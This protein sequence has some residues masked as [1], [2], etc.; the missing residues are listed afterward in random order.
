MSGSTTPNLGRFGALMLAPQTALGTALTDAQFTAAAFGLRVTQFAG[1]LVTVTRTRDDFAD[2]SIFQQQERT[3]GRRFDGRTVAFDADMG[4]VSK[5][6][7]AMFGAPAA[8]KITPANGNFAE[9]APGTP[10]QFR[11]KYPGSN[12]KGKD[13]QLAGLTLTVPNRANVTGQL[14]LN[15]VS[16][17]DDPA[18]LTAVIPVTNQLQF[19]HWYV[20]YGGTLYKPE[21]GSLTIT[22]PM[23]AVDGANGTVPADADYIFGWEVSGPLTFQ[24]QITLAGVPAVFRDAYRNGTLAPF[25]FGFQVGA[26]T[27]EALFKNAEVNMLDVPTG[28]GRVATPI[29]LT[30]ATVDGTAPVEFTVPAP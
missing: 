25:V 24:A 21:A 5:I 10:M 27:F 22:V 12:V 9:N 2:G 1:P 16:V 20:R 18:A 17:E 8:G 7:E 14:T 4:S 3:Q 28:L 11:Q 23:E 6:L 26:L 30:A 29:T 15:G 13:A 19:K